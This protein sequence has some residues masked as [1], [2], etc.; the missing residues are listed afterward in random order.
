MYIY[1]FLHAGLLSFFFGCVIEDVI[2]DLL[3][4]PIENTLIIECIDCVNKLSNGNVKV[5]QSTPG[6]SKF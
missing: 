1:S 5:A 2:I 4:I 3:M 6:I